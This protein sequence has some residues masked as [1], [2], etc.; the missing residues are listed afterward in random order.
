M[1]Q[2]GLI[3]TLAVAVV[4][5]AAAITTGY[6]YMNEDA[7][8]V[9]APAQSGTGAPTTAETAP[10]QTVEEEETA[11][12]TSTPESEAE[13]SGSNLTFDVVGV[14]PT[15]E[16]VV[17]GRSDAGAIVALTANGEVVGKGI[18]NDKGEWTIILEDPLKPGDYDVGLESQA[19]EEEAP[20][21][22]EQ[23]LAVSIPEDTN[24]QPLVVLN[25]PDAPSDILQKPVGETVVAAAPEPAAPETPAEQPAEPEVVAEVPSAEQPAG[26][27]EVAETPA[28]APAQAEETVVAALPA[29]VEAPVETPAPV[30]TEAATGPVE[31]AP[32]EEVHPQQETVAEE[33]ASAPAETVAEE[34]PVSAPAETAEVATPVSPEPKATTESAAAPADVAAPGADTPAAETPAEE[35]PAVADA[36]VPAATPAPQE[37]VVAAVDPAQTVPADE[38]PVAAVPEVSAKA[39]VEDVSTAAS[40]EAVAE[41]SPANEPAATTSESATAVA[42]VA[43]A[44][45]PAT[46]SVEPTTDAAE[47]QQTASLPAPTVTVTT[48]ASSSGEAVGTAPASETAKVPE[49]TVEAVE[50]ED[51][52]VFVAGEGKPQSTVRVYVGED[53]VGEAKTGGNGRWLVEGKKDIAAGEVEVRADQVEGAQGQVVARA[54]VTFEKDQEAIVLTKVVATGTGGGSTGAVGATGKALPNVIIRKGDNLWRIS[55]RLY[56][57]G[58]R[59]T[60]IYQANQG[61][62][63]NPDLIY[64]GQVFLTPESDQ[65]WQTRSN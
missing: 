36:P 15:G 53:F 65:N 6:I 46:R 30:Q 21:E 26:P 44:V 7:E 10:D 25:T 8:V 54:A 1:T 50:S 59:Y 3:W 42:P 9:E 41:A 45:T 58:I 51:G 22:S 55:R 52:K 37:T 12:S 40:A 14:E 47:E 31:Q 39:P 38:T 32:Q 24:E 16:A 60:T 49:V 17:A 27:Q 5:G 29:P 33:P 20:V 23:R 57:Q 2:I 28:Q 43:P 34:T 56:G 63:R 61:Q 13:G 4:V 35:S 48:G 11:N 19:S 62:I 18:A 64:P